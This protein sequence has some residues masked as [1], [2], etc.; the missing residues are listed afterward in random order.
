MFK[1]VDQQIISIE[2][3]DINFVKIYPY[4]VF[5]WL[6]ITLELLKIL[7]DNEGGR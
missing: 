7:V 5:P 2:H 6:S 3:C 4:R 1:V